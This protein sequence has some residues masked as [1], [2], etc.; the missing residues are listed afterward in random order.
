MAYHFHDMWTTGHKTLICRQ[1]LKKKT[2]GTDIVY[3][4]RLI[5]Q[6]SVTQVFVVIS[7]T[8]SDTIDNKHDYH[9]FLASSCH[10][11]WF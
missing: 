11:I 3:S 9:I 5:A 6:S 2:V 10:C 1:Q 7:E 8:S 4:I